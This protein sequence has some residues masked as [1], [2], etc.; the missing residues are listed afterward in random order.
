MHLASLA[1]KE[2]TNQLNKIKDFTDFYRD[3]QVNL[4]KGADL[5]FNTSYDLTKLRNGQVSKD[6]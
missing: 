2:T 5:E 6:N 1:E 3:L 4:R